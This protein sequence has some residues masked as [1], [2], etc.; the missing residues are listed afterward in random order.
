[1]RRRATGASGAG[2]GGRRDGD[3]HGAPADDGSNARIAESFGVR[4]VRLRR[5]PCR[6]RAG[7]LFFRLTTLR[8]VGARSFVDR[9]EALRAFDA[10]VAASLRDHALAPLLH[11][12]GRL[13]DEDRTWSTAH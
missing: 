10:E 9:R 8:A 4:L 2:G 12:G 1:M 13:Q 11:I 6:N 7:A 3:A 5:E